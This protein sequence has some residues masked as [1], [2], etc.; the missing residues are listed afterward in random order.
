MTLAIAHPK[1]C[2]AQTD[3]EVES[4]RADLSSAVRNHSIKEIQRLYVDDDDTRIEQTLASYEEML[5]SSENLAFDIQIKEVYPADD[6]ARV[7]WLRRVPYE[8]NERE[9]LGVTWSLVYVSSTPDGLRILKEET[10]PHARAEWTD[11]AVVLDPENGLLNGVVT[12]RCELLADAVDNLVFNLN[13]DPDYRISQWT[14]SLREM[15]PFG[16]GFENLFAGKFELS[17]DQMGS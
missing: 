1:P 3:Q 15:G 11:L 5:Q 10:L 14:K 17:I 7:T 6:G 2:S 12:V 16:E 9:F 8:R 4:L 13:L